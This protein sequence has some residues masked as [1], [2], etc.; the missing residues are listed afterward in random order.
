MGLYHLVLEPIFPLISRPFSRFSAPYTESKRVGNSWE[1]GW[2]PIKGSGMMHVPHIN[3]GLQTST[4]E[5]AFVM[6]LGG[7]ISHSI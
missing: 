5:L 1:Q 6:E 7:S 3:M 2:V 4:L